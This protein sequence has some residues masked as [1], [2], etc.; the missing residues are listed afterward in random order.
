MNKPLVVMLGH[1]A[2]VGKDL[3]GSHLCENYGFRRF[4]FADKLKS[5][6][7]DL[8]GFS[9]AQMYTELKN[10]IDTRYNITPRR[11]LQDFGQEQRNRFPDIWADY[12]FRQIE[13]DI[14]DGR[15]R[16]VIT[17]FRFPNEHTV[18]ARYCDRLNAN[19][20]TVKVTRDDSLR[21][22]FQGKFNISET[23]LD[24]FEFDFELAN[25]RTPDKL[26]SVFSGLIL[27]NFIPRE[28]QPTSQ[29]IRVN[30]GDLV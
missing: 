23:A 2:Q 18:A 20:I 17:D 28:N 26:F 21:G 7:G 4:A 22:D 27:V 24:E 30:L 11:V 19:L 16:F 12:V 13:D 6:V 25:N 1:K 8:Y 10:Q 3:L 15:N 9:N 14:S 29:V 5:S